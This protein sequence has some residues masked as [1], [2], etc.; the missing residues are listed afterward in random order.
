VTDDP[1][2][3][4]KI[5]PRS[6]ADTVTRFAGIL[7]AKGVRVFDMIDQ[8]AAAREVGQELRDT[9]LV[10]FGSPAAGT[11]V[12]VAAPLA[13]LDLPLKVLIWDDA[14]QTKV[15][16]VAPAKL[17]ARY[18]L[19]PDLEKNLEAINPLTDALVAP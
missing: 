14:G 4:T 17:A 11:P 1:G 6:V 2:I 5:S 12:M 10:I 3:V 19:G 8:A 18:Q 7:G 16:Y 15:T 9:T 13:A